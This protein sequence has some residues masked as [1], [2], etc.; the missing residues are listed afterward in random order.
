M[1]VLARFDMSGKVALLSGAGRGIGAASAM[2]LAE[3][4]ADIVVT[5]RSVDQIESVAARAREL[6]RRAIAIPTDANDADAVK[7]AVARTVAE[8]GRIDTV[9]S[10]VGGAMPQPFM[11]T[12]DKDLRNSFENNVVND[13]RL[14]RECVP[15]LL[16]A[17]GDRPGGA[18]VVMVSSA[19]GHIVGRGYVSYGSAKAAL[20]HAVEL[21][22]ADLNPRIRVNAVAPGAILTEALE[23][24]AANPELKASIENLTPLRRLGEPDDI[25]AAVLYLA[26]NASSYMTG[27]I[28]AVDGGTVT[29]NFNFPIADL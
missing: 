24:V 21:M 29:T 20:D 19:I 7:A 15:H 5:A 22:A 1:S 28:L 16:A 11:N 14:V 4:G 3:A 13:L 6:G 25:A 9:V 12:T 10:V 2:A 26:S 8:F 27:Q 18:S 23:I 17:A